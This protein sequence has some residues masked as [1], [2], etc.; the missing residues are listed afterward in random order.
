MSRFEVK[1]IKVSDVYN[2]PNADRLDIVMVG[3]YKCIT[4]R[5]EYAIDDIIVYIPEAAIVPDWIL[6][7][8]GLTGKLAGKDKNRVKAIKLRGILSQGLVYPALTLGEDVCV[9]KVAQESKLSS[10]HKDFHVGDDL[11]EVLGIEKYVPKIPTSMNGEVFN[12]FGMTLKY[13]IENIKKFPEVFEDG[14]EVSFTEKLHGCIAP[15]SLIMLP[16]GE[17]VPISDI[18]ENDNITSVL[19]Y[20]VKTTSFVSKQITAKFRRPN[21][22]K[23][24]W[25]NM[26]MENGRVLTITEDHPV[27]SN[28]R[29]KYIEAKNI[30]PNEDIKSPR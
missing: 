9:V 23:K 15:H 20:D 5:D 1:V 11:T 21:K 28:D 25:V 14:E 8:M 10:L 22:E 27:F 17:E 4:L 24:R 13:D 19:S 12:A 29:T 3:D 2:H 26:T 6:E 18:I 30:R 16:N 7:D